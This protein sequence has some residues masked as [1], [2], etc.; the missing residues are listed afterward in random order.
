MSSLSPS[1]KRSRALACPFLLASLAAVGCAGGAS[2]EATGS[3]QAADTGSDGLLPPEWGDMVKIGGDVAGAVSGLQG[4]G[5]FVANVLSK[6]GFIGS[7]VDPTQAKLDAVLAKLDTIYAAMLD[8][9]YLAAWRSN[10][11]QA[12][13][14]AGERETAYQFVTANPTTPLPVL[15]EP[16][17]YTAGALKQLSDQTFWQRP[18]DSRIYAGTVFQHAVLD[19]AQG[20]IVW[21]WR[22]ALPSL[23]G[24]IS[25]RL[26][27]ASAVQPGFAQGDNTYTDDFHT[28]AGL[29]QT[30]RA[31]MTDGVRCGY[32]YDKVTS[33]DTPDRWVYVGGCGDINTG[34]SSYDTLWW[35]DNAQPSRSYIDQLGPSDMASARQSL[36]GNMGVADLDKLAYKLYSYGRFAVDAVN[37]RD[38]AGALHDVELYGEFPVDWNVYVNVTCNGV[39]VAPASVNVTYHSRTQINLSFPEQRA[40]TSCVFTPVRS[41]DLLPS[42]TGGASPPVTLHPPV[43]QISALDLGGVANGRNYYELWG[44][45]PSPY[46]DPVDSIVWCDGAPWPSNVEYRSTGQVNVSISIVPRP[47]TCSFAL[48]RRSDGRQSPVWGPVYVTQF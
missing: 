22:L 8:E 25:D 30:M 32:W 5:D 4:A 47:F 43:M 34:A 41:D 11:E 24:V 23:L 46:V 9:S 37:D 1:S 39:A 13:H 3:A 2:E 48:A 28:A 44:T 15:S 27:I 45:F 6:A 14:S 17:S 35:W 12:D 40:G 38:G 7:T 26:F 10:R 19:R 33:S 18:Y 16:N 29:L 20:G 36:L 31:R 42:R 21:D